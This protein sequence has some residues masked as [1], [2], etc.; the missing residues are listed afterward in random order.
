VKDV[1]TPINTNETDNADAAI[2]NFLVDVIWYIVAPKNSLRVLLE[3]STS[4]TADSITNR[5]LC[6]ILN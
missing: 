2:G 5:G 4:S 1:L 6:L 3:P